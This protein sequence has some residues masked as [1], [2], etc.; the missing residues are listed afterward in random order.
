MRPHGIVA[1]VG[2]G[3]TVASFLVLALVG[4]A[5][6]TPPPPGFALLETLTVPTAN[7]TGTGPA[8]VTSAT[9]LAA[10]T[11]YEMRAAGL[12]TATGGPC[13]QADAE[14][15]GFGDPSCPTADGALGADLGLAIGAFTPG[16]SKSPRWG[17]A[18]A[19]NHEYT[20]DFVGQGAPELAIPFG[21][22]YAYTPAFR[23]GVFV[24]ASP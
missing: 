13:G 20:I 18:P 12:G 2:V 8:F 19:A 11:T 24:G 17:T 5:G 9:T 1:A 14:F 4:S 3:P 22:F 7:G 23:G 10:G 21:S 15:V 16:G 6:A